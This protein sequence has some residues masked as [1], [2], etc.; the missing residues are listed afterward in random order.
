MTLLMIMILP[1]QH[2][3][4]RTMTVWDDG[5]GED[6]VGDI[7]SQ[8]LEPDKVRMTTSLAESFGVLVF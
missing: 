1:Y 5:G 8:G 7:T 4:A 6:I 2:Y 3:S